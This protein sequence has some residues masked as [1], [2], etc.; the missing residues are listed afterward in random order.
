MV[1]TLRECGK[2]YHARG[3]VLWPPGILADA[4]PPRPRD[5]CRVPIIEPGMTPEK[6]AGQVKTDYRDVGKSAM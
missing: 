3:D 5:S 1:G 6:V 2:L 4:A